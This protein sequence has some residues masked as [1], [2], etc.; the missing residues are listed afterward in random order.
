MQKIKSNHIRGNNQR[1]KRS[2]SPW[3]C[4]ACSCNFCKYHNNR[5]DVCCNPAPQPHAAP[6]RT[7]ARARATACRAC[8]TGAYISSAKCDFRNACQELCHPRQR[9]GTLTPRAHSTSQFTSLQPVA[10][11]M[12]FRNLESGMQ[13]KDFISLLFRG[14]ENRPPGL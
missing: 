10:A 13:G 8:E 3:N 11:D 4:V 2:S 14:T 1:C 9:F 5:I 6:A 12:R 7:A